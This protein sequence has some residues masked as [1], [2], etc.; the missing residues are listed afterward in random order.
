MKID[1]FHF[2]DYKAYLSQKIEHEAKMQKGFRVKFSNHINCQQ[3]YLSQVLHGKPNLTLEQAYRA[4]NFFI[5]DSEETHFFILLVEYARAGTKELQN[6]FFGQIK[7]IRKARFDL[8]KRLKTTQEISE[9]DQHKYYSTWFYSAIH[10]IL[11]IPE[12]Q[13]PNYI[14]T[15]LNLPLEIVI[16]SIN[17]LEKSGLI[18]NKNGTYHFTKR[19]IH[20]G[21]DSDFIQRHHINWRSQSLQSVEKN[22]PDDL[23]YSTTTAISKEDFQKL[24]EVYIKAIESGRQIIRPSKEEEIYAITLDVFRL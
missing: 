3:S 18:E 5:H 1:L 6:Y 23:H 8:K 21:R 24:K 9:E 17:F 4:N 10:V 2:D 11:S 13:D 12:M 15:R 14:S 20:L 7:E 19:S 16:N 22:L